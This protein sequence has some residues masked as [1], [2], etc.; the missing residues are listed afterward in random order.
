MIKPAPF[1]NLIFLLFIRVVIFKPLGVYFTSVIRR[2]YG[3]QFEANAFDSLIKTIAIASLK[4]PVLGS[5][6]HILVAILEQNYRVEHLGEFELFPFRLGVF[7][8]MRQRTDQNG[9]RIGSRINRVDASL[10]LTVATQIAFTSIL[11]LGRG[12]IT[13]NL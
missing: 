5:R 13:V 3:R 7:V 6:F 9:T 2:E 1:T 12:T 4:F 11:S 10:I 8:L